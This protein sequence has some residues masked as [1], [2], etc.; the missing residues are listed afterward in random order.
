M[1]DAALMFR[2]PD[3]EALLRREWWLN[4]ACPVGSWYGDDG[5]MQCGACFTDFKRM[6]LSELYERVTFARMEA[7]A[8]AMQEL[9][10]QAKGSA[11][12]ADEVI[13]AVDEA[14]KRTPGVDIVY[15]HG[16]PYGGAHA[17]IVKIGTPAYEAV[18]K[19]YPDLPLPPHDHIEPGMW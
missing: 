1:S 16:T 10:D 14:V 4:H 19:A 12:T 18:G 7:G 15:V 9:A 6:P 17:A 13:T 11:P 2:D 5:E 8:K 3:P